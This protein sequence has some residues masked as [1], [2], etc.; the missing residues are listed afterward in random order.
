MTGFHVQIN[1][2]NEKDLDDAAIRARLT[3]V[4]PT[5][6]AAFAF[7][8]PCL[9]PGRQL[10]CRPEGAGP[11]EG[12]R[13]VGAAG[14]AEGDEPQAEGGHQD[15]LGAP[16]SRL[17]PPRAL[18]SLIAVAA[19]RARSVWTSATSSGR[20]RRPRTRRRPPATCRSARTP[21]TSSLSSASR[22]VLCCWPTLACAPAGPDRGLVPRQFWQQQGPEHASQAEPARDEYNKTN[23]RQQVDTSRCPPTRS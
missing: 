15:R 10:R 21:T 6:P 16:P 14:R 7:L 19:C 8:K 2:R 12:R 9:G 1:A 4:R 11:E 5:A 22:S 3:K 18:P 23:E 17:D 13:R 20:S